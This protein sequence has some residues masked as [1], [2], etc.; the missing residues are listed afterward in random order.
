MQ[1]LQ[2]CKNTKPPRPVPSLCKPCPP[3]TSHVPPPTPR[4]AARRLDEKSGQCNQCLSCQETGFNRPT[5]PCEV[6]V[7]LR[8]CRG[9]RARAAG[10]VSDRYPALW[11]LGWES[12]EEV[13]LFQGTPSSGSGREG[14]GR[15]RKSIRKTT[16]NLQAGLGRAR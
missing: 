16:N 6:R 14:R 12:R 4:G 5:Q 9:F 1:N 7:W 11:T 10:G 3:T 13:K 15:T 8:W 2:I